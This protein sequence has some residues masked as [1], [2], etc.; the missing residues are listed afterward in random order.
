MPRQTMGGVQSLIEGAEETKEAS[1]KGIEGEGREGTPVGGGAAA[2]KGRATIAESTTTP[3]QT[4]QSK[5]GRSKGTASSPSASTNFSDGTA[6]GGTTKVR[7][8]GLVERDRVAG[9]VDDEEDY[10][11]SYYGKEGGGRGG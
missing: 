3:N 11:N 6:A 4:Q 1:Q 7:F 8:F 2:P 10:C 5:K 9:D